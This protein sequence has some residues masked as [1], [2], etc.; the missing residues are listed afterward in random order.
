MRHVTVFTDGACSGNPGPGGWAAVILDGDHRRELSGFDAECGRPRGGASVDLVTDR[1]CRR[2]P[3]HDVS[4]GDA[5]GIQP[6]AGA[7]REMVDE[8]LVRR[9]VLHDPQRGP[10]RRRRLPHEVHEPFGGLVL[11]RRHR[12]AP[13]GLEEA[14]Q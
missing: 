7:E 4:V 2:M 9:E 6:E 13:G 5:D 10:G 12:P 11:E 14:A 3:Q 8:D 1:Q